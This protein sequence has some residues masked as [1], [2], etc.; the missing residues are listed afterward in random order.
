MAYTMFAAF[1]A[2]IL[3]KQKRVTEQLN[4]SFSASIQKNRTILKSIMAAIEF[5]GRQGI[6]LRG[7]RDDS[8]NV[9]ACDDWSNPGNFLALLQFR[10]QT[11]SIL[12][13]FL[14]ADPKH[15]T[16]TSKTIQ[17]EVISVF[18]AL[19]TEDIISRVKNAPFFVVIAD[20]VQDVASTEQLSI[21]LRYV[22]KLRDSDE[23]SIEERFV[24]FKELHCEMTGEAIASS[25]LTAL[26]SVGLDCSY[27][28]GQ[29]YDGS[30]SMAGRVQGASH[31][32]TQQHPLAVQTHCF[33]H[34]LNLAIANTCTV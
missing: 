7:H 22:Y 25:I 17:N 8:H 28:R 24:M 33:S 16:Y 6:A 27:L 3:G 5:C 26:Q 23:F 9:S 29:G 30:G 12:A 15:A 32:I 1:I 10:A 4:D 14:I 31:R 19:L 18:G 13:D 21:T 2:V 20:E 34:V 11:D